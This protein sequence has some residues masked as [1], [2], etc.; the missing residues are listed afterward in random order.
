MKT[1]RV[2]HSMY[3]FMN[4]SQSHFRKPQEEGVH[5]CIHTE[6]STSDVLQV[7]RIWDVRIDFDV[8]ITFYKLRDEGKNNIKSEELEIYVPSGQMG[9]ELRDPLLPVEA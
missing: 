7:F 3:V 1:R 6:S 5:T 4:L 8:R 2:H 9:S